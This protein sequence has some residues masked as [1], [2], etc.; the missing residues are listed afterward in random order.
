MTT[1]PASR[2]VWV[3][4]WVLVLGLLGLLGNALGAVPAP[5]GLVT[6]QTYSPLGNRLTLEWAASRCSNEPGTEDVDELY[7]Y[8]ISVFHAVNDSLVA[9]E[10]TKKEPCR[11]TGI[12]GKAGWV[13]RD[14]P[15]S[16]QLTGLEPY[17]EYL[18]GVQGR[19]DSTL[20]VSAMSPKV[21]AKPRKTPKGSGVDQVE[22]NG[23]AFSFDKVVIEEDIVE[24][25]S[26]NT[27][28]GVWE[29]WLGQDHM[30]GFSGWTEG[31]EHQTLAFDADNDGDMDLLFVMGGVHPNLLILNNGT[32]D[33]WH[34]PRY[35]EAAES[36]EEQLTLARPWNAWPAQD[37]RAAVAGDFNGDGRVDIFIANSN[38]KNQ[39][40]WG[41]GWEG[42]SND[43]PSFVVTG[44]T[45]VDNGGDVMFFSKDSRAVVTG[46]FD[47]DGDLD[48]YVANFKQ[49]NELL[50]NDGSGNFVRALQDES[51]SDL[52]WG[53]GVVAADF[54]GDGNL[55]LYEVCDVPF[56]AGGNPEDARNR[57]YMGQGDGSFVRADPG[58]D[59]EARTDNS[60]GVVAGDFNGDGLVDIF[61]ASCLETQYNELLI[62]TGSGS[63]SSADGMDATRKKSS[64]QV[65]SIAA[66]DLDS[67]GDLD[68]WIGGHPS[69][70]L[71]N[72]GTAKFYEVSEGNLST[73]IGAGASCFD[74]TG[75]GKNDLFVNT[76]SS[77]GKA[78]FLKSRARYQFEE[79]E[80]GALS[81][82]REGTKHVEVVDVDD[83]G[84]LVLLNDGIGNFA[85]AS[86]T[87]S[88]GP[89]D[90]A[91]HI[92]MNGNGQPDLF[93]SKR[94]G[95]TGPVKNAVYF[96]NGNDADEG[97]FDLLTDENII[98][99]LLDVLEYPSRFALVA[100]FNSDGRDDLFLVN[101]LANVPNGLFLSD[102][103]LGHNFVR[104]LDT[105][106]R[107]GQSLK[108]VAFD[109]DADGDLDIFVV[110]RNETCELLINDGAGNFEA[111]PVALGED[112]EGTLV[113]SW[114]S[115]VAADFNGDGITDLYVSAEDYEDTNVLLLGDGSGEYSVISDGE[116]ITSDACPGLDYV[117]IDIDGDGDGTFCF[118]F[119]L[120]SNPHLC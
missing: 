65:N 112:E 98:Q 11:G 113:R 57:L 75:D 90:H 94:Q 51:T 48:L 53:V 32:G 45:N 68:L 35:L 29:S 8:I 82:S 37:S 4:P 54:D 25:F 69:M 52:T 83:D 12:I 76:R 44:D 86:V 87:Q 101:D 34:A 1:P 107:A 104:N 63:F 40:Y 114:S 92:D 47:G 78:E 9:T 49:T 23:V 120:A 80:A 26:W 33:V 28:P 46:D 105:S 100:D 99:E 115:A 7:S 111:S 10:E 41:N 74:A 85:S 6:R 20:E 95:T 93:I 43:V 116:A 18:V 27:D 60:C 108:A 15:V 71:L 55:D 61:V 96:N 3:V 66:C 62:N 119:T 97:P 70:V 117:G 38:E 67:D 72:D 91:A 79:S 42:P 89:C 106:S 109:A 56:M 84:D 118:R 22:K 21:L 13:F 50:L 17:S 16:F 5:S 31:I 77:I 64:K 19:D 14:V 110:Y 36:G 30:T 2:K 102:G 81:R 59:A 58:N 88:E 24:L 73:V 103:S 39:I